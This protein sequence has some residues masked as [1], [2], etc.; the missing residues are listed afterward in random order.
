VVIK[1]CSIC[2][3]SKKKEERCIFGLGTVKCSLLEKK[4]TAGFLEECNFMGS[5][6]Q[7]AEKLVTKGRNK[8]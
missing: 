4:R 2:S 7:M 8:Y 3:E 1:R 6:H 5:V